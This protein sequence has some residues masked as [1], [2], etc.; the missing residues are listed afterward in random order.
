M[1]AIWSGAISF[2]LVNI[3]IKLQS[4]I[5][6]GENIDFDLLS[7]KDLAP[8]RYARI[9]TKTGKEVAWKDIVKGFQ[10]AK[11]KYVIVTEDDFAKAS[12]EKSESIDI[13][14]F[15]KEEEIDPMFYEKPYYV[16]PDKGAAKAYGL[17][18]KA[19]EKTQTVGL[20]EFMLRNRSHVCALKAHNGVLILNQMRYEDEVRESP[21]IAEAKPA[22]N[23]VKEL[24]LAIKLVHQLT[25]KFEPSQFKDT[26]IAELR[27][28]IKAKAAGK[29]IQVA[30]PK[31]KTATVKDLM[32]ILKKSLDGGG[33]AAKKKRA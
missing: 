27:K 6:P 17:L 5:D 33:T 20:A 1:R 9:D 3:P 22:K 23:S 10:Y 21:E 15:V 19:L 25:D 14:Q 4:A 31:K 11:G 24:D 32:E 29:K 30:E 8:I 7:K 2:G 12:P 18:I 16:I 13:V 28:L 26:Y